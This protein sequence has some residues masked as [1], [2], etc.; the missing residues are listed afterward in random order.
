VSRQWGSVP[1]SASAAGASAASGLGLEGGEVVAVPLSAWEDPSVP[2]PEPEVVVVGRAVRKVRVTAPL[3]HQV[4]WAHV[5]YRT[6]ATAAHASG[7][8]VED[9]AAGRIYSRRRPV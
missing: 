5:R 7:G 2:L 3:A 9:C 1:S 6:T 4:D 8:R